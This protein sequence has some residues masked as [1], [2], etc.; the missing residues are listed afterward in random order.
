MYK[1]NRDSLNHIYTEN[2]PETFEMLAEW[3]RYI[4]EISK[5]KNRKK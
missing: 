3:R 5:E 2:Q 4:D 1:N